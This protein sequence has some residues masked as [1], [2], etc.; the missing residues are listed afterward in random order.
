[1]KVLAI[2]GSPRKNGNT[3]TVI[4]RICEKLEEKGYEVDF[5]RL[6][7]Y[8]LQGC[9]ACKYCRTKADHCRLEDNISSTL[10]KLKNSDILLLGAPN[11]MGSVSGQMKIFLDRMFSL[12]DQERNSRVP[13]GKKGILIFSQGHPDTKAYQDGYQSISKRI[14]SNN[15]DI[16]ETI[17]ANGVEQPGE[18]K[19]KQNILQQA[20]AT[21]AR[22]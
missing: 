9:Q 17:I 2:S 3:E 11:Y 21:A 5:T 6:N 1:M 4:N 7:D 10:E 22:L 18:V 16:I 15:I 12:K 19:E 13:T 8:P 20:E 14:E